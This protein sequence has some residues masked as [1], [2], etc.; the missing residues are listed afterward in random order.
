MSPQEI[1]IIIALTV[2]AIYK[3]STRHAV[4]G[5]T[6]FKL[7]LIY[8]VVGL[9]AGGFYMPANS[10]AWTVLGASIAASAV[11]GIARGQLSRVWREPDGQAFAQGTPLTI[12]L[13]LLLVAGKFAIGAWQYIEHAPGEHGGFGEVLL[14]IG[15]MVGLQAETVWRR[16]LALQGAATGGTMPGWK[17]TE[18]N[19][20]ESPEK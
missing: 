3:Q 2:Y 7:A 15:I 13:F 17:A 4:V 19:Q 14:L 6:R 5:R 10:T 16:A 18:V 11:V 9:V 20:L 8:M 1:L 12:G